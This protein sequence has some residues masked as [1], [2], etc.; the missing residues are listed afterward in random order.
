M[1][2]THP[3]AVLASE[4]AG[5]PEQIDALKA[6]GIPVATVPGG[7]DGPAILAKIVAVGTFLG[8]QQAAEALASR[9]K[10]D[11]DAAL[12]AAARPEEKRLRVLFI[13]SL[14][15]GK[16]VAAG[17]GS[18]AAAILDMAGA[19]N[20]VSGFNGFKAVT[21]EAIFEAR[22]DAILV[23][24]R[25]DPA[26]GLEDIANN[27][28]LAATPAVKSGRIIRMDGL[29]LLGFGPRTADAVRALSS[30]LYGAKP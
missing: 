20:A 4:G 23:M 10:A 15:G 21:A 1:L 9:V 24:E 30:A 12:Q 2:S 26:A 25:G 11:L 8:Q 17:E 14:A 5:P 18:S 19:R 27:P 16:V 3:D 29:T 7:H 6:S 28:A 13:L 22:P